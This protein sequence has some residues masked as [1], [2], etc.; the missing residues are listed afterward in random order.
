MATYT[1]D[2]RIAFCAA[3]TQ[4]PQE[5]QMVVWELSRPD[6]PTQP[7]PPPRKA[8]CPIPSC[9]CLIL[10]YGDDEDEVSSH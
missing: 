9:E 3:T 2:E 5:L 7:P 1:I 6:P 10:D 8:R 4:L